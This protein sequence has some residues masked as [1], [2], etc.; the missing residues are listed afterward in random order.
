MALLALAVA[1]SLDNV[2]AA[3]GLGLLKPNAGHQ[4][5]IAAVFGLWDMAAPLAGL[6]LGR[7]LIA[8]LGP[9]AD[10]LGPLVLGAYGIYL[11]G[12][13]LMSAHGPERLDDRWVLLGLPLSLSLDNLVA[14]VGLGLL[15]FPVVVSDVTFGATTAVL[16]WLAL[17]VGG[18]AARYIPGRSDR[19]AGL[20]LLVV[21][22]SLL[23]GW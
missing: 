11:F 6:L 16:S 7:W 10:A 20:V 14:G 15:G 17:R 21:A 4:L 3:L 9:W 5:R 2:R 19:V 8:P 1:L 18:V 13:S 12:H 22:I 23:A